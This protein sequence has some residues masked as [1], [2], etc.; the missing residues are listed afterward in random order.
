MHNITYAEAIEKAEAVKLIGDT[1][2]YLQGGSDGLPWGKVSKVECGSSWRLGGP[3]SA[4]MIAEDQGL[5]FKWSVDFEGLDANGKGASQFDR[6][7]LR[8]VMLQLPLA[9]R[10]S[11]ADLLEGQVLSEVAKRTEECRR[12]LNMNADSEDCVRGLIAFAREVEVQ[13]I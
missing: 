2:V 6:P 9:A 1:T 5:T 3:S 13:P 4:Y 11:F 10:A 8:D 12:V 7:R